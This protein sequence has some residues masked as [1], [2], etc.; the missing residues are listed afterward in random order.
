MKVATQGRWLWT[1]AV[2]STLIGQGLD[3]AIFVPMAFA[4]NTPGHTLGTMVRNQCL[5]KVIYE[6]AVIP[7]TYVAVDFLKRK[8]GLDTFDY[9]TTFNPV[10]VTD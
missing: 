10:L 9:D 5:S 3:S 6:T 7:F 8:E 4:G 1:R 2:G